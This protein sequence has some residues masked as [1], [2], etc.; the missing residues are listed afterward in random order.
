MSAWLSRTR[1]G[2]RGE[3]GRTSLAVSPDHVLLDVHQPSLLLD[4]HLPVRLTTSLRAV[5]RLQHRP[6][7]NY[8]GE[9]PAQ[10]PSEFAFARKR[11]LLGPCKVKLLL[12]RSRLRFP[13]EAKTSLVVSCRSEASRRT[14]NTERRTE[15][16]D[17]SRPASRSSVRSRRVP[18]SR[19]AA[20][21]R[22][23]VV[24]AGQR[25]C[26]RPP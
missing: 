23:L 6:N 9:R 17:T 14:D 10:D 8:P 18:D 7:L 12:R 22:T 20:A 19:T 26:G 3:S 5:R 2:R 16:P 13:M 25:A 1:K 24:R 21:S 15:W 4:I 11:Q